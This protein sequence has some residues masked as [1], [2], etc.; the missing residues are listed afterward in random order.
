[1]Y[2]YKP[3]IQARSI[4][5]IRLSPSVNSNPLIIKLQEVP[6]V[7][8]SRFEALSYA[9]ARPFQGRSILCD[10]EDLLV[11]ATVEEALK[12]LRYKTQS[13]TLWIDQI[14]INQDSE[15]ERSQQVAL[16]GDVYTMAARVIVWLGSNPAT[17]KLLKYVRLYQLSNLVPFGI[18]GVV[19]KT[20][21]K[22]ERKLER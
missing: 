16:M 6:L 9:W 7:H 20:R 2:Q 13:R 3:L 5:V 21:I 8:S 14:C 11:S 12:R 19:D 10:G 4:R 18:F 15:E 1:M 17:D 22:L